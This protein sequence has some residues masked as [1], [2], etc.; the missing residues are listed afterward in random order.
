MPPSRRQV[1]LLVAARQPAGGAVAPVQ[2]KRAPNSAMACLDVASRLPW[3]RPQTVHRW[4]PESE[5][6]LCSG[7]KEE[8][9]QGLQHLHASA[10]SAKEVLPNLILLF[11]F[12]SLQIPSLLGSTALHS[13][14]SSTRGLQGRPPLVGGF[15]R[16]KLA[17]IQDSELVLPNKLQPAISEMFRPHALQ[18]SIRIP[19]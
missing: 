3:P 16:L 1:L 12:T 17:Q 19:Q 6:S 4:L 18:T 2:S 15:N 9:C 8:V 5:C 10:C 11:L 7:Q 13:L 14:H